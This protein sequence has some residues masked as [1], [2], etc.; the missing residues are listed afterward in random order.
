MDRYKSK[1]WKILESLQNNYD[2]NQ[3]IL[4]ITGMLDH[5][6]FIDHVNRI[7][8]AVMIEILNR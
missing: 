1:E 5:E 4:T 7:K 3:D 6:Q 8:R 2:P